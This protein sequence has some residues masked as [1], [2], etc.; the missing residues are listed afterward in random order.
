MMRI[1]TERQ[2]EMC[3]TGDK[4]YVFNQMY[5]LT[6]RNEL[7]LRNDRV[8]SGIKFPEGMHQKNHIMA[9]CVLKS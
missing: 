3:N 2:I 1:N 9:L 6:K 7:T 5:N 4:I 8:A